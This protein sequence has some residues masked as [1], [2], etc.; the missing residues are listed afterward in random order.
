[1]D[2]TGPLSR[3]QVLGQQDQES[4]PRLQRP[5]VDRTGHRKLDGSA[6]MWLT[7]KA[8]NGGHWVVDLRLS[9]C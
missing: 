4:F 9:G 3:S 1:M 6:R 8:G 5:F 7:V 2:F